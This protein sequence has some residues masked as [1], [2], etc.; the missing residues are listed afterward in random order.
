MGSTNP[1]F[2]KKE[3]VCNLSYELWNDDGLRGQRWERIRK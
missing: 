3:S 1:W 2:G